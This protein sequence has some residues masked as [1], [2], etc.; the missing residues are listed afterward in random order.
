MGRPAIGHAVSD[1]QKHAGEE[2]R[3]SPDLHA[4]SAPYTTLRGESSSRPAAPNLQH[5]GPSGR[6]G[7]SKSRG[8]QDSNEG[9][10]EAEATE[11]GTGEVGDALTT[12][13]ARYPEKPGPMPLTADQKQKI[14]A[15]RRAAV[16]RAAS[17]ATSA[18][19]KASVKKAEIKAAAEEAKWQLHKER[20]VRMQSIVDTEASEA[21]SV[22]TNKGIQASITER[23]RVRAA[24]K[25]IGAG[26]S[27]DPDPHK[28]TVAETKAT[29]IAT[30]RK[31]ALAKQKAKQEKDADQL[32]F[33][34]KSSCEAA[35][36]AV[37]AAAASASEAA[38][39][40]KHALAFDCSQQS[41]QYEPPNSQEGFDEGPE[42][43]KPNNEAQ[44]APASKNKRKNVTELIRE[45]N[46]EVKVAK[47]VKTTEY[48]ARL[49]SRT[50]KPPTAASTKTSSEP[51]AGASGAGYDRIHPSHKRCSLNGEII[52]C[53]NCGYW[54][55]QKAQNL[56]FR[57]DI[58]KISDYQKDIRRK[59]RNRLYPQKKDG[60]IKEWDDG[61]ST[62]NKVP[63]RRLDPP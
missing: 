44:H 36:A 35:E 27:Q 19:N 9:R 51:V 25:A 18:A 23:D 32:A 48:Q 34:A 8:E 3:E 2:R 20:W 6:L 55:K 50:A 59:L 39:K 26:S 60:K 57:C 7:R 12:L 4:E 41:S 13:L 49:D 24:S 30:K 15:S 58:S 63:L 10:T 56:Q 54:M 22:V 21:T 31:A 5:A 14:Y 42:P 17:L 52:F 16:A 1:E 37:E 45:I 33:K 43:K 11:N 61:T 40:R 47:A 29:R 38:A 62:A 28:P 53:W 46:K